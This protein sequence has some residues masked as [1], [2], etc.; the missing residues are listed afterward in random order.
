MACH[1]R[2]SN[3]R[4]HKMKNIMFLSK[5][6]DVLILFKVFLSFINDVM[7]YVLETMVWRVERADGPAQSGL[8]PVVFNNSFHNSFP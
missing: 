4:N 6:A 8:I 1:V 7:M 2:S 5:R 3:H